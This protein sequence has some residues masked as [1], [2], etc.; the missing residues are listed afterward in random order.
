MN[1]VNNTK[2]PRVA[3]QKVLGG[4]SRGREEGKVLFMLLLL[5]Q[6]LSLEL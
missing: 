6:V 2:A 3:T 5:V 4:K 1:N